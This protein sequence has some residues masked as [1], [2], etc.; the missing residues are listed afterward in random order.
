[1][2]RI[3]IIVPVYKVEKYLEEC[4]ESILQ[5]TFTDYELIL[6][7]DGSPDNCGKICDHYKLKDSRIKVIHQCN[8][9]LSS[10]RNA[11]LDT[12]EGEYISFIDSDD[13]VSSYYL[14]ELYRLLISNNADI[15]VCNGVGFKSIEELNGFRSNHHR[16][17]TCLNNREAVLLMYNNDTDRLPITAW[18]KLYK[19]ELFDKLR[20]PVGKIH[21]DEFLIPIVIYKAKKI[22]WIKD[23]IYGYRERKDS[24]MHRRFSLIRY[25]AIEAF[26]SCEVFFNSINEKQIADVIQK[27]E[28][29]TIAHFSLLARKVGIYKMLPMKYRMSRVRAF[30]TMKTFLSYDVYSYRL[31]KIYPLY[32]SIEAHIRRL[33]QMIGLVK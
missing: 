18:G 5:Q 22:I 6:I 13:I 14:E 4:I 32:I 7:D 15:A 9:G 27:W 31:A 17:Q 1:M 3:S 25:D 2:P 20:F 10:A 33:L 8:N 28:L 19:K 12:I 30:Y 24:I 21:E 26:E 11:G 29:L 23:S 16:Q